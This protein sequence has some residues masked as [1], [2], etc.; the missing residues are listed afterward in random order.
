MKGAQLV[1]DGLWRCLCPS[2]ERIALSRA[3]R[4]PI[5][6]PTTRCRTLPRATAQKRWFGVESMEE[7]MRTPRKDDEE[8]KASQDGY[9]SP[10]DGRKDIDEIRR[11]LAPTPPTQ[12]TLD[13][14]TTE[15]LVKALKKI[16]APEGFVARPGQDFD[17]FERIVMFVKSLISRGHP[18]DSFIYECMVDAMADPKGSSEGLRRILVEIE[19]RDI[20]LSAAMC[21]GALAALAVHPNY[22]L[23]QQV[24]NTMQEFWFTTEKGARDH[25]LLAMLRE[26]QYERA[27]D[28]L[29]SRLE[30]E[31]QFPLWLYDIFVLEF[32]N[33]GFLD[34]MIGLL[35]RRKQA[36]GSD[37]VAVSLTYYCLDVCSRALHYHGTSYAWSSCV[38]DGMVNPSD[39]ILE[40]VLA[41]AAREGDVSL[42]AEVHGLIAERKRTQ[43]HH[44]DALS[45][46]FVNDG[47]I[48][49]ALRILCIAKQNG[50]N[51]LRENTRAI[52]RALVNDPSLLNQAQTALHEFSKGDHIPVEALSV[53]L[54]AAS[55]TGQTTLARRLYENFKTL[56]GQEC[57]ASTIEDMMINTD[58]AYHCQT[59]VK[60]YLRLVPENHKPLGRP[61]LAY[62]ELVNACLDAQECDLAVRF[63]EA[64]FMGFDGFSKREVPSWFGRLTTLCIETQSK[65]IWRLHDECMRGGNQYAVAR[66]QKAASKAR[67]EA[68]LGE[69]REQHVAATLQATTMGE[70]EEQIEGQ[71][72][73]Q[74]PIPEKAEPARGR[75]S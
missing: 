8:S 41:T 20:P 67:D 55:K 44:Y 18:R 17:R 12:D 23:R 21:E 19:Q 53:V 68:R 31:Q 2:W 4:R 35:F 43:L 46:A 60:D 33:Q 39:G 61:I 29:M 70:Q 7:A 25:I 45:E 52:Y 5:P 47:N 24:L 13:K 1:N 69:E 42:A 3:V 6:R 71:H 54:E 50:Q 16:R 49:G 10:I 66:I 57:G 28:D 36:K 22:A 58:D 48:N 38:R 9:S 59:Y 73:H 74:K 30:H 62:K 63:A 15:M 56:T 75:G 40:N 51:V 11:L 65:A 37:G 34:E 27:Y 64:A 72:E 26:G 14:T 32:G